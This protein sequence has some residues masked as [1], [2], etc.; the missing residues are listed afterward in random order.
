M[1]AA[2]TVSYDTGPGKPSSIVAQNSASTG[3]FQLPATGALQQQNECS[4]EEFEPEEM[5]IADLPQTVNL[6]LQA[7]SDA[8][9][10]LQALVGY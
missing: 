1:N 5:P 6:T 7:I 4:T 10:T 2:I 8:A 9:Q 3:R